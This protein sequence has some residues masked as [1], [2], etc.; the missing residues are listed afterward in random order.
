[1]GENGKYSASRPLTDEDT[2]ITPILPDLEISLEDV[3]RSV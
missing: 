2:I 3:F 1:L